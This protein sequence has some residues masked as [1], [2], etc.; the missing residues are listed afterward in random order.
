MQRWKSISISQD[1]KLWWFS[2]HLAAACFA[3][4]LFFA[5]ER[6]NKLFFSAFINFVRS[7]RAPNIVKENIKKIISQKIL[8]K[9]SFTNRS[10]ESQS[11]HRDGHG[12]HLIVGW[13]NLSLMKFEC[14]QFGQ[15]ILTSP[16]SSK[17]KVIF[18]LPAISLTLWEW[19]KIS[20][21]NAMEA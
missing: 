20:Q 1:L 2:S 19:M 21:F 14:L 4:F 18:I 6:T 11:S 7:I 17:S 3:A 16:V 15:N 12:E 13:P 10:R 5:W 9:W 8:Y